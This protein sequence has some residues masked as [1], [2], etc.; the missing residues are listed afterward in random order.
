MYLFIY[1]KGAV[2]LLFLFTLSHASIVWFS[3]V[4]GEGVGVV[5]IS[6]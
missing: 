6:V 2:C 4:G 1:F 5:T 3:A